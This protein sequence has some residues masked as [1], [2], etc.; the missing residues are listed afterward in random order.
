MKELSPED[1]A[2]LVGA[3][4][5]LK[6]GNPEGVRRSLEQMS[7]EGQGQFAALEIRWE[8]EA[9]AGRWEQG[10]RIATAMSELAPQNAQP[11]LCQ[12]CCLS[13]LKRHEQALEMLAGVVDQFPKVPMIAY[14]LACCACKLERL[15]D[16]KKWLDRA[17]LEGHRL[18]IKLM[19]LDDP[20]MLPLLDEVCAL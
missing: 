13:E 16:A 7:V 15:E 9:Q 2:M 17:V 12:A 6:G 1:R 3:Q 18:E 8:L 4:E 5:C 10:L 19:A 20:D 14:N 11:W